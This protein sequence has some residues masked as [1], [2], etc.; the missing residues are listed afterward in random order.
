[1]VS[2]DDT[3]SSIGGT[4][5]MLVIVFCISFSIQQYKC[6]LTSFLNLCLATILQSS[7]WL[8]CIELEHPINYLFVYQCLNM[9]SLSVNWDKFPPSIHLMLP[10]ILLAYPLIYI[11]PR[12]FN[13][14]ISIYKVTQGNNILTNTM[15][16]AVYEI[17]DKNCRDRFNMTRASVEDPFKGAR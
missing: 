12:E 9:T 13:W 14:I 10:L 6:I 2:S 8:I 5:I 17:T 7:G 15:T 11:N 3:C 1:M 16:E 4:D